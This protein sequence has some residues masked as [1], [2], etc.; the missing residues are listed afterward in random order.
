MTLIQH[1]ADAVVYAPDL[2]RAY[3]P[4]RRPWDAPVPL[5]VGL[6]LHAP[7]YQDVV[8]PPQH[9]PAAMVGGV[10]RETSEPRP[11]QVAR[12]SQWDFGLTTGIFRLLEITDRLGAPCA[13]ALDARGAT[14]MPGLA[15]AVA[16]RAAEVV[17]RGEAAD[18]VLDPSMTEAQE[19]EAITR[20]RRA[21]EAATGRRATGWFS[22]ERASTPRT[23]RLLREEGFTWFGDWPLDE[24]PVPLAGAAQGL[25]SLPFPLETEDM[26][27]L[28]VRG[29]EFPAYERVLLQTV[30]QLLADAVTTGPRFLGLSWFGWVL[31]Q[32]CFADVAERVL[33][34][35]VHDPRIRLV[36]PGEVAG[37]R[38]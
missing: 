17:V 33:D 34:R 22:P 29:L 11:G 35:L 24:V 7:A 19:R 30:D 10:G 12:L 38:E 32:A 23:P 28:Y 18:V 20:S 4:T 9:K 5:T 1:P 36:T 15:T 13:V 14:R 16:A 3:E 6:L 27:E 26:F 8:A 37:G 25:V 21:V 31:G 2:P